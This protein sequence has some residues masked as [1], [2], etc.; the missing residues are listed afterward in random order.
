MRPGRAVIP[1]AGTVM[2]PHAGV[3]ASLLVGDNK[4]QDFSVVQSLG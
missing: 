1:V 3:Q 2:L 4:E